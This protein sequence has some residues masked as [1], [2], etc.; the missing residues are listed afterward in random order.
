M[1]VAKEIRYEIESRIVQRQEDELMRLAKEA[2]F[3]RASAQ[4]PQD[5][6]IVD[7]ETTFQATENGLI[8][9]TVIETNENIS[10]ASPIPAG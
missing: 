2:S 8:A 1:T 10:A 4:V 6:R 3:S 9:I 7:S 5:A